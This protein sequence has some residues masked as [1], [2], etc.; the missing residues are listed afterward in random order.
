MPTRRHC[1]NHF[2]S[3]MGVSRSGGRGAAERP[4]GGW[5]TGP[6]RS[7]VLQLDGSERSGLAH[8]RVEEGRPC[9]A[10][11]L[12]PGDRPRQ[13]G[14]AYSA[15]FADLLPADS[16]M[17]ARG[18]PATVARDVSLQMARP[19]GRK[20]GPLSIVTLS[21]ARR[22]ILAR[23]GAHVLSGFVGVA[24]YILARS[25]TQLPL[26]TRRQTAVDHLRAFG[27]ASRSRSPRTARTRVTLARWESAL[28]RGQRQ[29]RS[30]R[31][32][33]VP[34]GR[35][36]GVLCSAACMRWPHRPAGRAGVSTLPRLCAMTRA[37]EGGAGSGTSMGRRGAEHAL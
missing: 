14:G 25:G 37:T 20:G 3:S 28:V 36:R 12:R 8:G 10:R 1:G 6:S 26:A 19:R 15:G 5:S 16:S 7:A 34:A 2:G 17:D 18:A 21:V 24:R 9:S 4:R 33:H 23:R 27:D 32:T 30:G 31:C 35:A 29:A 13:L 11:S 22:F